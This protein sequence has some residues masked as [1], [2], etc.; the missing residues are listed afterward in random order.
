MRSLRTQDPRADDFRIVRVPEV[1][2]DDVF[3]DRAGIT[4]HGDDV[5]AGVLVE[6]NRSGTGAMTRRPFELRDLVDVPFSVDE[7]ALGVAA[8]PVPLFVD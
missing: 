2:V 5:P 7:G 4:A 6:E 1:V 3:D 8:G